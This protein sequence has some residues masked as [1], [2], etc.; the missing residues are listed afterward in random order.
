MCSI[1]EDDFGDEGGLHT[2]IKDPKEITVPD[3]I[4]KK[5]NERKIVV[6]INLRDAQ[7]QPCFYQ[8]ARHKFR[9]ALGSTRIVD[10][11]ARVLLV[12][13]GSIES[14]VMFDMIRYGL[15]QD[16]Y[17]RITFVPYAIYIDDSCAFESDTQ[18]R[19]EN[20]T[21]FKKLLDYFQFESY[22]TS[23]ATDKTIRKIEGAQQLKLPLTDEQVEEEQKFV[24]ALNSLGSLTSRQDFVHVSQMN[25]IRKTAELLD[26][27]F[28]FLSTVNHQ[29]ATDLLANI[30]LG[31]G[32]SVANEISICDNRG[33][34]KI[35]RPIRNLSDIEVDTYV[36]FNDDVPWP[37][38]VR[39]YSNSSDSNPTLSLQNL[40]RQFINGLQENFT[41][42]VSTVF[43]TGDKIASGSAS[44]TKKT[45]NKS[46]NTC[47]FCHSFLDYEDSPTLFAIEYSRCVSAIA[48]QTEVNDFV[49]MSK[50]AKNAVEGSTKDS[51]DDVAA[52]WKDLCH[53]CRNIFRDFKDDTG[54]K[55]AQHISTT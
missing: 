27:K 11:G 23:I 4:C 35:L 42:T 34:V 8:Y 18:K 10:R 17:K 39:N 33:K 49:Q 5:C 31:R 53:G 14:C 54:N 37:Q 26:C 20:L 24:N 41:S 19:Q 40:T 32:N 9:A 7:C 44:C 45:D 15:T 38:N 43:R 46:K 3:E 12:F 52:L 16:L 22:Y 50:M 51:D 13:D 36:K 21:K 6:K 29:I 47:K 2:M 25:A 30:A 1:G 55:Y 48:D 28:A